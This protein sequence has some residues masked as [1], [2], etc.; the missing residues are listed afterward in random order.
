MATISSLTSSSSSAAYGSQTKGIG[1]LASGLNTDELID[2]MTIST[3]SKIAKQKQNK[4]LLSWKTDA[5]RSISSKLIS[6]ADKYTSYSSST[7]LFSA[8]F[9][10]KSVI[11][12]KGENSKYISVSGSANNSDLSILGVKE[13]ARDASLTTNQAL[14]NNYIETGAIDYGTSSTCAITG[15]TFTVEYGSERYVVTMPQK[16]SGLYTNAADVVDGLTKA[17]QQVD[18]KDGKKLSDVMSV[19]ANG[20]TLQFKNTDGIGNKLQIVSGNSGL[21]NALGMTAGSSTMV[22]KSITD[23]GLDAVAQIDSAALQKTA[24][25][26]DK[27]KDKALTFEYN[28][29]KKTIKFD[30]ETKLT[31]AKFKDYLQEE[32]NT[33]FGAGRIKVSRDDTTQKI[34]FQTT[35]PPSGEVDKTSILRISNASDGLLG[36]SGVFGIRSGATNKLNLGSPLES[37]GLK[38][39]DGVPLNDG[40]EYTLRIN[41]ESI[42]IKYEKGKTTLGDILKTINDNER[43]GVNISYQPNS[44]SF[45]VVS[46]QSGAGGE[47]EIGVGNAELND[48]EKLLFGKRNEVDGSIEATTNGTSVAGKDAVILVDFDG[49]GGSAPIEITRGTNSFTLDGM[50]IGVNGTFGYDG[51]GNPISGTEAVKFDASVDTDKIVDAIKSMVKDYNELVESANS[52]VGEKR[53]RKF[54][55]LTDEQRKELSETEIKNW[56][57][58][59]KKGMLFGDPDIVSLT[60]DLRFAFLNTRTDGLSFSDIGLS[61]STNWKDNGKIILDE[62]KLKASLAENPDNVKTLFTEAGDGGSLTTGGAMSRMKSITDKYAATTGATKGILVEKA[63]SEKSPSSMLKNSLLEQMKDIDDVVKKLESKLTTER[64]RYQRQFTA[65]EQLVQQMNAQSGWLT[66][67]F[68][69]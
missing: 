13:L 27:M 10:D 17:L 66:Q 43:A 50:T 9:Y 68:G 58:K 22:D 46:T 31:E 54:P 38:N 53:E 51:S 15:K 36:D 7:N 14:S 57:E 59:A 18:I 55:P 1:G 40:Q 28:A 6:F 12:P 2:G 52:A 60:N 63:G 69:G 42:N 24:S 8:G 39:L 20:E 41:G 34:K 29:V 33:A 21:M 16:E 30:D 37:S 62:S 49:E 47:V 5:F 65:L 11:S 56:E 61:V 67:Q 25:F 35:T 64:T 23:A 44:D 45:S 26:L 32:L 48:L 19:T 3:R 4:T